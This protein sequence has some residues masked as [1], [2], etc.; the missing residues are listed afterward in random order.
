M[1]LEIDLI[2]YLKGYGNDGIVSVAT[3]STADTV[4]TGIVG[5]AGLL[6]TIAAIKAGKDIALAN[7]ETLIAGI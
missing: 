5:C 4:V 6:P 1:Y 7:K 2:Q 3:Y